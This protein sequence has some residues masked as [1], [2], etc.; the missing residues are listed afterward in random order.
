MIGFLGGTLSL[1]RMCIDIVIQFRRHHKVIVKVEWPAQNADCILFFVF[2]LCV[3]CFFWRFY[4]LQAPQKFP[5]NIGRIFFSLAS[6]AVQW[7]SEYVFSRFVILLCFGLLLVY[8]QQIIHAEYV[9]WRDVTH[10]SV[11]SYIINRSNIR[12]IHFLHSFPRPSEIY[13]D[14]IFCFLSHT[15]HFTWFFFSIRISQSLHRLM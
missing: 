9:T 13:A 1:T 2:F 4:R 3:C 11:H 15:H 7:D 8:L 6:R 12:V 14:G 5:I 10:L